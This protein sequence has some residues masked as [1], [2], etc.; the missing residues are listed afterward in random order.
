[1]AAY[2]KHNVTPVWQAEVSSSETPWVA[3][4][5]VYVMSADYKLMAFNGATGEIL[6]I[7]EVQKYQDLKDREGLLA[8]AGPIMAGGRLIL[9]G[10]DGRM[11]EYNPL[12]GAEIAKWS[13]KKA[14]NIAPIVSGGALYL[15]GEDGSL[16]AYR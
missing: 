12:N 13:V 5:T 9:A 8:W 2:D 6:W 7:T 16:L 4:N 3:G 15:L 11:V 1:M 14:I 10:S